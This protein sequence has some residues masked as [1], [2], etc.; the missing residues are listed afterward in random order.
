MSLLRLCK[1][2]IEKKKK[3][4]VAASHI[5][6]CFC[7]LSQSTFDKD[8]YNRSRYVKA[9]DNMKKL[10]FNVN[11]VFLDE[12]PNRGIGGFVN[13]SNP[14]DSAWLDRLAEYITDADARGIYTVVTMVYVPRNQYFVNFSHKFPDPGEEWSGAGWNA[15]FLT[16]RGQGM[17]AEYGAQLA[18]YLSDRLAVDT[19]NAVII[20]LQ[21]EFFLYG[22]QYPFATM[23]KPVKL[24]DGLTYDM[25]KP[26]DR[27]AA[28]DRNT[29]LWARRTREQIR[30]HLPSSL[31]TVGM[32]TY[33]AVY[34]SGPNGLM[35]DGCQKDG[36]LTQQVDCR[37]PA[38]PSILADSSIDFLDVHIY[39]ANGT[40]AALEEN[41]ETEEW[42]NIKTNIPIMMGEFGCNEEW[43]LNATTCAPSMQQLQISS[44]SKGFTGWMFWTY[45]CSE[46]PPP[47]WYTMEEAAGVIG[48]AL[49]PLQRPDPCTAE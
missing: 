34:K 28:A 45:D 5:F 48:S 10:G 27:Q 40:I 47:H 37:F 17:F 44:C 33:W 39:Q 24:A 23:G 8:V 1:A 43:G 12:L 9:F 13:A 25:S 2:E 38:R 14:L 3:N 26:G 42:D 16:A 11:R 41:L 22:D 4:I 19:Q 6:A 31:V 49:S 20:S 29:N 35:H 15:P 18:S 36:N 21:N 30:A 46:Q 32:F 7:F